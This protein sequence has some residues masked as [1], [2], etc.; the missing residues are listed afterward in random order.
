MRSITI[1]LTLAFLA[2]SLVGAVLAALFARWNT[3][4][5]FDQFVLEQSRAE[6]VTTV[7]T[8]YQTHGSWDGI[9]DVVHRG[10]QGPG[11]G[12]QGAGTAKDFGGQQPQTAD[13]FA[14]ADDRHR[15][16][17][18]AGRFHENDTVPADEEARGVNVIVDSRAVGTV[19]TGGNPP[20]LGPDQERFIARNNDALL[21]GGLGAAVIAVVL[22]VILAHTLAHPLTELTVAI[23]AM[24]KGQLDQQVPV[25]SR[26]EIG[27]LAAAFNQLSG[28]LLRTNQLRRQMTADIAHDLRTPLTVIA[29]YVESL[30]DGVLAPTVERFDTI[31][32]EVQ[33]LQHLVEDLRTLSLADADELRLNRE[34][35]QPCD[36]LA[37]VVAT[38]SHT[39]ESRRISLRVVCADDM[40]EIYVDA[41][42][43]N[44]VF[45]NLVSNALRYTAE[46]GT[47]TLSAQQDAERVRLTV[48]DDGAGI[49]PNALPHIFERFYRAD[50]SRTRDDKSGESGLG[51][52]IARSIV[53][54][55][56]GTLEA[57][58]VLGHGATFTMTLPKPQASR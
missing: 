54:A 10:P 49:A 17:L 39:A 15:V 32:R 41:A 51:L 13:L 23:R 14:L 36:L 19:L 44:E 45:G 6:F 47:I 55:H 33:N 25:R 20:T 28:D 53:V 8:Y 42:R 21:F 29:G 1:R 22:G 37:A 3:S 2:V 11:R 26:D 18:P 38:F 9:R 48:A 50:E 31:Y 35:V 56:G 58:S 7:T 4:R 43:M 5:Q 34:P 30:R 40:P 57:T 27:E 46:G 24:S 16:I 12:P 52:A